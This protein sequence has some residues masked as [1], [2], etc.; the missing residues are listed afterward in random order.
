M[1]ICR[2]LLFISLVAFYSLLF[3]PLLILMVACEQACLISYEYQDN[4][5]D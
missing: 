2:A 4:V 5:N 1:G 3:L